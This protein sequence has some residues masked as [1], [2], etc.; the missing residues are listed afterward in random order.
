[1]SA[2]SAGAGR[3]PRCWHAGHR[4][5]KRRP[6][7]AGLGGATHRT[8]SSHRPDPASS[9]AAAAG[10]EPAAWRTV[11]PCLRRVGQHGGGRTWSPLTHGG[12]GA[13]RPSSSCSAS[14]SRCGKECMPSESGFTVQP[15]TNDR[16]PSRHLN[17]LRPERARR[18]RW[19]SWPAQ[20]DLCHAGTGGAVI[21]TSRPRRSRR[22]RNLRCR[23]AATSRSPSC[24]SPTART[25]RRQA[26]ALE[27]AQAAA[28][29][30]RTH[31]HTIGLGSAAGPPSRS[32][33]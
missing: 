9:Y 14:R 10:F 2:C 21:V 22:A 3:S 13:P 17:R 11:I 23:P 24:C 33:D 19:A 29:Q 8:C 16:R 28:D 31:L 27:T 25:P 1:M 12:S 7:I 15:P 30:G 5:G 6:G 4:A 20:H 26:R 32:R 18:W